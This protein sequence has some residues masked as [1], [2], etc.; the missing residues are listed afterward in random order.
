MSMRALRFALLALAALGAAFSAQAQIAFR[1]ASQAGQAAGGQIT[2]VGSGAVDTDNSGGC[3]NTVTPAMPAGLAGDVL[4][5]LVN[6]RETNANVSATGAWTLAWSGNY[7]G[8]NDLQGYIYYKVA[9]GTNTAADPLTITQSNSCATI[10]AQVARFRNVDALQPLETSP[11]PAGNVVQQNSGDLDTGTQ[12]TT[13]DGSMLLV[14]GFIN[15]DRTVTEGGGWSQAFDNALNLNRDLGFSLHYQLQATAGNAS[16]SGWDLSGGGN[17]ENFGVIFALRPAGLTINVPAGTAAEDVMIASVAVRDSPITLTPP[18]GWTLVRED[19]QG[20]GG[21]GTSRMATYYRVASGAEPASYT[22]YFGG[23]A[24]VGAAGVISSF[25]GVDTA[26]PIDDHNGAATPSGADHT[27]PAVSASVFG[28]MLVGAFEFDSSTSDWTTG[29]MT[30]ALEARSLPPPDDLGLSMVTAY[31]ALA[32]AGPTGS[33]T[34]TASTA[35]A[36][37]DQGVAHLFAL[38]PSLPI[39]HWSMDEA[40]WTGAAGEVQDLSGNGQHGTA[41]NGAVTASA[42]PVVAGSPGTCRYGVLDGANQFVEVAD[43]PLLDL[44]DEFTVMAWIRPETLPGG[45]GLMTIVSKDENFEFHLT[46]TGQI[47]WWWG[48]GA[49]SLTSSGAVPTNAWTHVAIVYSRAGAFQRIYI[50]GA[51]DPNTNNQNGALT[52]NADPFQVGG[53]QGL[54]G[55]YFDGLVDEVMVFR[56][57]LGTA[58]IQQYMNATRPCVS[59]DHYAISHAGSGV[60]CDTHQITITAHDASHNPVDAGARTVALATTNNRGTWTGIAAG[61]GALSDP[62][63]GDGAATYQFAVGSNSVVLNFRYANLAG[64]SETFGFNVSDGSFSE[65]SGTAAGTEDPS[66]TMSQAGFRF[67]NVTDGNTTIPVQISGK[68]SNTGWNAKTIRIQAI[69][70]DTATGSCTSL[71]ASQAR[72]VDLGAECN[73]PAACAGRQVSVN[74]GSI[75]TSNDNAGAGAAAYSSV[76]L[77][78]NAASEADTVIAYPDAGRISLHAR[79]DLDPDVAGFEALGASN[80]FVVRPF[81]LA[82]PGVQHGTTAAAPILAAAG[83]NF[84]LTLRA[85]Q[86]APGE[87]AN[88]DGFP[89]FDPADTTN[90]T[91]N[92]DTPNFAWDTS[93]GAAANLPGVAV[94]TIDRASGG[95]TVT[96]LEFAGGAATINNWRYSEAGNVELLTLTPN[97]IEAGVT[98]LG[99]SGFD[100]TGRAAG[101]VGRFRPKHFAVTGAPT[102]TNRSALACASTFTYLNEGLDLDFTLEARNA[103]NALTQNYTGA[104]ARLSLATAASLGLGARSGATDLTARADS[105]LA[106]SGAFSNGVAALTVTTGVRRASPDNP[107][108]PFAG[109]QFGIAPVDPDGVAMGT[110]DLD[111]DGAGGNDHFAVGP[112]T[113]LRFGRL[114]L[115]NAYGPTNLPL[116]LRLETQYWSGGGFVLNAQDGC[117]RLNRSD[118]ALSFSGAL[119]ACETAVQEAS[120]AFAGGA[121]TAT[122]AAPGASNQGS[123]LLAPQLGTAAGTYCP[124]VGAGAAAATSAGAPYLLGRWNDAADPDGDANSA[125]D[126][127]P[128]GQAAFGLYGSQPRN[129]IFQRE[130]Y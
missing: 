6:S 20:G 115:Q 87:D 91:D 101:H 45:G 122:L 15:D 53:D 30:E 25:S 14:A 95:N 7:G 23:G 29:S 49:L 56:Q 67:N 100:G 16:V 69:Q 92:G 124:S 51:Q 13:L 99:L 126:D 104:Y 105:S 109:T 125:Y 32:G 110:L 93:V 94:G 38:R 130:N 42:T 70:T 19:V 64:T 83:D 52:L 28:A 86:W 59:L 26:V 76:P 73:L 97:Y 40:A 37:A 113:E 112:T 18:A 88:D 62:A 98:L 33:R 10:S 58:R 1:A 12:A 34:A 123:V 31:E 118:I 65:T 114:R 107:D 21:G 68:P 55:R 4:V 2:Y 121:A 129:F 3:N 48:G 111:V 35:G 77:N 120:L 79:F 84:T 85:Y 24:H 43:N 106:P 82:F 128:A 36:N 61:G 9:A 17:D 72:S 8:N 96:A 90:I 11:I 78:F 102:L 39:L 116:P 127:N 80:P 75:A 117:T 71:F 119:A 41:V 103:Q 81:G 63:A 60:A 27:A 74:G 108:G 46:N 66:F 22:W 54:A 47:N 5:A 44:P 50:N 89:D 57:A